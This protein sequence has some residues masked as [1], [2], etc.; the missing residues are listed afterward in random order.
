MPDP[1]TDPPFISGDDV[2]SD[3]PTATPREGQPHSHG[4]A[5]ETGHPI[6]PSDRIEPP[7]NSDGW[8]VKILARRDAEAEA[9]AP[10]FMGIP[11][12][13]YELPGPKYRCENG[14]VS[15]RVL[16]SE[17]GRDSCLACGGRLLMTFPEDDENTDV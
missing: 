15:S 17:R 6:E 8:R 4:K 12:R 13:W 11:D 7:F 5:P 16:K 2:R 1:A 9:G 14:H 3:P 10:M